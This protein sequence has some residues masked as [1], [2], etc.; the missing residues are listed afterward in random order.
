MADD[1]VPDGEVKHIRVPKSDCPNCGYTMDCATPTLDNPDAVPGKDDFTYC[2][3]CG[4]LLRFD[5][6]L[7]LARLTEQMWQDAVESPGLAASVWKFRRLL[8]EMGQPNSTS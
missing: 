8:A 6:D 1:D 2:I 7:K 3:R 5:A 4:S